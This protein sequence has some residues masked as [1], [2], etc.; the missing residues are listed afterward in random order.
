MTQS[1]GFPVPQSGDSEELSLA[2]ETAGALW[3]KGDAREAVRWLRRAAE[4][5][6]D[7][8]DDM[9]AVTLARA[10]ADLTADLQIPPS[11]PAPPSQPRPSREPPLPSAPAQPPPL[12]PQAQ[13]QAQPAPAQGP[14][15]R[16]RQALRVAV[17]PSDN[18]KALLLVRVLAEGEAAPHGAHDA[19]LVAL[20][21]GAN[22][23]AKKR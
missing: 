19:L 21:A 17:T 9:R 4:S 5:A 16:P 14:T 3:A 2:L 6:G 22:L 20:E 15:A 11:M 12:P 13:A 23:V 1:S 10:A 7:A 8:G 18:D